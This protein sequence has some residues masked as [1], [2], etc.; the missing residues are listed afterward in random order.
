MAGI[1]RNVRAHRRNGRHRNA[2]SVE[3]DP[4]L[5]P[6]QLHSH[7]PGVHLGAVLQGARESPDRGDTLLSSHFV[8]CGQA[9]A[10]WIVVNYREAYNMHATNGNHEVWMPCNTHYCLSISA[11]HVCIKS[12][13]FDLRKVLYEHTVPPPPSTPP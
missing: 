11:V 2:S 9:V 13:D 6:H 7:L 5:R 10:Y 4:L 8:R 3:R 1:V 12:I